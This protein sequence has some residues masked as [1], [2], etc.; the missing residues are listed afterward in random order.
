LPK[1]SST[2]RRSRDQAGGC[3]RPADGGPSFRGS[4]SNGTESAIQQKPKAGWF[5]PSRI[6]YSRRGGE[7]TFAPELMRFVN[8][9]TDSGL[10]LFTAAPSLHSARE[11]RRPCSRPLTPASRLCAGRRACVRG[12]RD[13]TTVRGANID[14]DLSRRFGDCPFERRTRFVSTA[15]LGPGQ[16][17]TSDLSRECPYGRST[18]AAGHRRIAHSHVQNSTPW[19]SDDAPWQWSRRVAQSFENAQG[20]TPR[21]RLAGEDQDDSHDPMGLSAVGIDGECSPRRLQAIAHV[22]CPRRSQRQTPR[23]CPHRRIKRDS[24][25]RMHR[26]RP[27]RFVKR[28]GEVL[29][30]R[31]STGERQS[32]VGGGEQWV[33]IDASSN[34][35][36]ASAF[37]AAIRLSQIP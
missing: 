20:L 10:L 21:R 5:S 8:S 25:A 6:G 31:L 9:R 7:R 15:K 12:P 35:R 23:A 30:A 1:S 17:P 22:T 2:V 27:L 34:R 33:L 28:Q 3:A 13:G 4:G 29:S 11:R 36:R 18:G 37:P 26:G 24:L 14:V 16:R 32:G 19:R